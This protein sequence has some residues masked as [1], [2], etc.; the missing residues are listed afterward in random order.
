MEQTGIKVNMNKT[1]SCLTGGSLKQ[2]IFTFMEVVAEFVG[3][4]N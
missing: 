4:I 2:S 3:G 1:V